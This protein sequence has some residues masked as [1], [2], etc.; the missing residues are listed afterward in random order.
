MLIVCLIWTA[1]EEKEP[2]DVITQNFYVFSA[3]PEEQFS[4]YECGYL[5]FE[6]RG[7]PGHMH[8]FFVW[9]ENL[10]EEYQTHLSPVTVTFNYMEERCGSYRIINIINI[11]QK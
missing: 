2:K 10:P 7:E 4:K 5:L 6:D 1:C 9:S 11:Q 8:G 3:T